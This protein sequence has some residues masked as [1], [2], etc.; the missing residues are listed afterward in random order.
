MF[1]QQAIAE[2]ITNGLAEGATPEQIAQQIIALSED[3]GWARALSHPTRRAILKFLRAHGSASPSRTARHLRSDVGQVSYHFRA[4]ARLGFI[5]IA[6]T[7]P[8]R[9]AVEHVYRLCEN[10]R[11]PTDTIKPAGSPSKDPRTMVANPDDY[12]SVAEA[13][14]QAGVTP[15][16][17]R[18]WIG[19]GRFQSARVNS[20]TAVKQGQLTELLKERHRAR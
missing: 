16:T 6:E 5:E 12:I 7:I 10:R 19:D 9:G 13:V 20:R 3:G 4:L 18:N 14:L 15:P 1:D 8:R 11:A 2:I 17:I